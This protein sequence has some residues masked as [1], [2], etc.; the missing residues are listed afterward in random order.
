MSQ[1][2]FAAHVAPT[3]AP[4]APHMDVPL[5]PDWAPWAKRLTRL[6]ERAA[7]ELRRR[8]RRTRHLTVVLT[9]ANGRVHRRSL[10]LPRP[11][12]CAL[13]ALPAALGLLRLMLAE[14]PGRVSRLGVH[15]GQLVEGAHEPIRFE[16][17]LA[18]RRRERLRGWFKWFGLGA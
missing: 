6:T 10:A 7:V 16:R 18:R 11:T 12:D 9:L 8:G 17:Y 13:D 15:L 14:H 1:L 5:A 4:S 2:A 3:V